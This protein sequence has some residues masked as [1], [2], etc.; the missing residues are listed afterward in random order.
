MSF[1]ELN[2]GDIVKL[3]SGGA[4]MTVRDISKARGSAVCV[5]QATDFTPCQVEYPFEVLL[6]KRNP[7][8]FSTD[9]E[10]AKA[11]SNPNGVVIL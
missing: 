10:N 8:K 9:I 1:E 4:D 5:W 6:R 2:I 7:P 3:M 11:L